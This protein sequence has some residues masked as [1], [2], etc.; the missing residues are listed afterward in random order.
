MSARHWTD[1]N[2]LFLK[3][4]CHCDCVECQVGKAHYTHPIAVHNAQQ[5][6]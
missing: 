2:P 3:V 4:I 6:G 1:F 5:F